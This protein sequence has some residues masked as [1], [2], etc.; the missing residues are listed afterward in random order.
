ME[1]NGMSKSVKILVTLG[2]IFLYIIISVP[3]LAA[4]K[5]SG[6]SISFVGLV[7][8]AAL[9]GGLRAIWRKPESSDEVSNI[10]DDNSSI[11]QK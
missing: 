9:I 6:G 8:L 10:K 11:L 5:S 4:L 2:A 7:L 3:I 1:E